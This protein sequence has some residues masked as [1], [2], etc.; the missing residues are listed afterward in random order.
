MALCCASGPG[1]SAL[2][3]VSD[4]LTAIVCFCAAV[5]LLKR[6][7][8]GSLLSG[9]RIAPWLAA[10]TAGAGITQL[11]EIWAGRHSLAWPAG[12]FKGVSAAA[13][14]SATVMLVRKNPD[15]I[16][17]RRREAELDAL[18]RAL[19]DDK[20]H[21][22][23]AAKAAGLGFW[24]FDMA[25]Q[26]MQGDETMLQL[27]GLSRADAPLPYSAWLARLHPEDRNRVEQEM[28][29]AVKGHREFASEFRVVLPRGEVRHIKAAARIT[30][31][32]DGRAAQMFGVNFDISRRKGV[33][34]Q[35][36]LAIEAAPT[37]MLLLN[38]SGSIVL[39]NAQIETL[40]G[41]RREEL[42]GQKIEL[43]VPERFRAH[44]PDFRLSYFAEPKVR[45]MGAGRELYG[46]RKDGSELPVEIGLNPIHTSDGEFVLS[47]IIDLSHQREIDRMRSDFV[48]TVSHE[49]RSPL[50]SI[51]GSLGLLHSGATGVLPD[52]AAA[53]VRIAYLN[54]EHLVRIIN[55]I[56]DIGKL[57]SGKLEL[58]MANVPLAALLQQAI[59]ANAAYAQKYGVTYRFEDASADVRVVV[60]ADRLNQVITNLLTNAAKF[61][62]RGADVIIRVRSGSKSIL[63]EIEDFGAGIPEEFRD[64]VF[65][66]FMQAD[67]SAGRRFEGT[68]LG[69]SIA[70]KLV[71]AMGG[72]IGFR[73]EHGKGSTFFFGLPRAG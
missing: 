60:D 31:D 41:Y 28:S 49:L 6:V 44:H 68:G 9:K 7:R 24:S 50:T 42:L 21:F 47:S 5:M 2:Y 51:N 72:T 61:S 59:E 56:L 65:E 15:S 66:K 64:S 62:P 4:G 52:K 46:L 48:S 8:E 22:E 32:G 19:V 43:L 71:E 55:D 16:Q 36:R 14:V 29:N 34:E 17:D 30:R 45:A 58:K 63:V 38:L 23:M 53:M 54:S 35:F 67:S 37:G 12:I 18:N 70:R 3:V 33:D 10:L 13:V 27:Y 39:V 26:S 57:E 25:S 20:A 11:I 69:L 73:S 1:F 40:F